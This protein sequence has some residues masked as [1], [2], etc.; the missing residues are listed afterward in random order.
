[1]ARHWSRTLLPP[2]G[3]GC[4]LIASCGGAAVRSEGGRYV[5]SESARGPGVQAEEADVT[6]TS[7]FTL[8]TP[9]YLYY[10]EHDGWPTRG[11]QLQQVAQEWDITF[12]LDE[13]AVLDMEEL[14]DGRLHVRFRLAP[15]RDGHGE[16]TVSPPVIE[17]QTVEMPRGMAA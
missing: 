13:Y 10:V 14:E 17:R 9:L 11:E 7:M 12:D 5:T 6:L 4:L 15:P 16:F 8:M 2:L 1:M 3:L